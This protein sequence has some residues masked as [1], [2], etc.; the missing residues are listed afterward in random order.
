MNEKCLNN[1]FR[2]QVWILFIMG[3]T[4][5]SFIS[6]SSTVKSQASGKI[7]T[8]KWEKAYVENGNVVIT[9]FK[10][11]HF[12][13][14]ESDYFNKFKIYRVLYPD[15]AFNDNNEEYFNNTRFKEENC[16]YEG[17]LESILGVKFKFE[18]TTVKKGS[19]YAYWIA[20]SEG[21]PLGPMPVKIRDPEIWWS[22]EK[23][24]SKLEQL[25]SNY[26]DYVTIEEIG[27]SVSRKPLYGLKIGKGKLTI[28]MI[29]AIHP[30]ESGPEL[31][32]PTL[33]KL[34]EQHQDLLKDISVIAVPYVNCDTREKLVQGNPWYL[35]RNKNGVDLNRNFPAEWD[36]VANTYNYYT[37]DPDGLTY[38]GPYA[39]SEPETQALMTFLLEKK[40][41]ALF[42]CHHLA[43]ICGENLLTYKMAE[44]DSAYTNLSYKYANLF[45]DGNNPD[46]KQQSIG[47]GCTM[48]S[49]PAWCYLKLGIPAFDVEGPIDIDDRIRS[50]NDRTD[51]ILL[52]KYQE[53]YFNGI[54][55]ILKSFE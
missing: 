36:Q 1:T 47:F 21:N 48:G 16:I 11:T 7:S 45:W 37:S 9:A 29:G 41:L 26:P 49:L 46:M 42:S 13:N 55:N 38:R 32:I 10:T 8:L 43:S 18:D 50:V 35:R 51:L 15:F 3:I 24:I 28:A 17:S 27:L 30:G 14:K 5:F 23:I 34:L 33:E 52:E 44:N 40:P 4:M 39:G 22:H 25:K 2:L 19:V 6:C 20:T 12:W 53:K 31:I 54:L